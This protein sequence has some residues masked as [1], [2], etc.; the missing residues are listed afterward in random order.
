MGKLHC[1]AAADWDI[2]LESKVLM[3]GYLDH[4]DHFT[5]TV[6]I[7]T[8]DS[9]T[10]DVL[11]TVFTGGYPVALVR[12]K[13]VPETRKNNP[14]PSNYETVWLYETEPYGQVHQAMLFMLYH[15]GEFGEEI[16]SA[17]NS[18]DG[19]VTLEDVLEHCDGHPWLEFEKEVAGALHQEFP[20]ICPVPS[21]Y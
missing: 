11:A 14:N 8:R 10:G 2:S 18:M 20:V 9:M 13:N 7:A 4:P 19:T 21:G 15:L 17:Y 1:L 6:V 12:T 5:K 16:Y 3:A